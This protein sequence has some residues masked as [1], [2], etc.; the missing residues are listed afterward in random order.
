MK[1]NSRVL[2]SCNH[3]LE[4]VLLVALLSMITWLWL[5]I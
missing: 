3:K 1:R 4:I 2:R 5:A